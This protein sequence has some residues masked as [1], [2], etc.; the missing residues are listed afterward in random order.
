TVVYSVTAHMCMPGR[1]NGDYTFSFTSKFCSNAPVGSGDVQQSLT[2]AGDKS[3]DLPFKVGSG[4]VNWVNSV[5]F[6]L[7]MTCGPGNPC[8]LVRQAEVNNG[9]PYYQIPLCY[10]PGCPAPPSPVPANEAAAAVTP[11]LLFPAAA[12]P[13][14]DPPAPPAGKANNAAIAAQ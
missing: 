7:T 10:G 8:D 9:T 12:P 6:P 14:T 5:G 11:S 3:A 1:V 2:F 4:T 13:P